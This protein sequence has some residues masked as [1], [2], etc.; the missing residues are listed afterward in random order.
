MAHRA[1]GP[2]P[3][4]GKRA[5]VPPGAEV[6]RWLLLA[7]LALLAL[8]ALLAGMGLVTGL[9]L[10]GGRGLSTRRGLVTLGGRGDGVLLCDVV[11]PDH[12]GGGAPVGVHG[13]EF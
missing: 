10:G 6:P 8:L 5:L 2:T 4:L 7:G 12:L 3:G 13:R 1:A 9:G 11:A